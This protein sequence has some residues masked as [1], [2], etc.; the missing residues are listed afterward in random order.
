MLQYDVIITGGGMVGASLACALSGKGLRIALVEAVE[1]QTRAAPGYD[2]R[3]IALAFGT[4]RIFE[5]LQLWDALAPEAAPIHHIHV[6]DRGR[7]GM[8]HMDRAEEGLPALGYVVPARVIGAVLSAAVSRIDELD[9]FCPATVTRVSKTDAAISVDIDHDGETTTLS[10]ALLVAADGADSPL[11]EQ[12]GIE[13]IERDYRQTAIVTNI[14]PQLAHNNTAYERFTDS[15]PMA[16]L[17]M[18]GQ[19]CGVVWTVDSSRVEGIMALDDAGF[20]AALQQRFG[21]RLGRLDRVGRRQAWPLRL[22]QA[23]ESVRERLALIGNAIHT[24]HPVAGQGF[25]LGARDVAVLAEVLV[26][27]LQAGEDPGSLAVLNRYG[28]WRKR[29]HRNV[30]VFTD[31]LAR[32]FTLPLPALGMARSVGMTAFDLL[33]PAK[34]LLTRLTMGRS[35]RTPRLVR[36]LPL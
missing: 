21:Y 23:R 28:D 32:L 36:G 30:A 31:G 35:G 17:P 9:S 3:A 26:D 4:R 1:L 14:T 27:A 11:R 7:F 33:P 12:F 25:N 34:R 6:S 2:D 29:D 15:G 19:R 10:A 24:L 16:L 5:G 22:V 18:T 8:V 13:H 20:L